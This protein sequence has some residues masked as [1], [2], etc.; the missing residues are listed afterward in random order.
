M[1]GKAPMNAVDTALES[2]SRVGRQPSTSRSEL[3]HVALA[4]FVEHG[5]DETTV[6]DIARAVGVGRRTV[7]RYFPSKNDLAWGDFDELLVSMRAFLA[8]VPVEVPIIDALRSAVIEFNHIPEEEVLFHRRRMRLL[9][10][11]PTL[12]AHSA[13]RYADWRQVVAEF[14]ATRLGVRS[15]SLEPQ[16]MAWALL[17]VSISAYEQWLAHDGT[18]LTQLLGS[19]YDMLSTSF[20]DGRKS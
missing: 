19:A 13:L 5:F 16:A 20:D 8:V 2:R 10:T 6:D 9:L 17:G 7:F 12:Q 1:K 15:D 11:V 4:L 14:V 18:S 3:A